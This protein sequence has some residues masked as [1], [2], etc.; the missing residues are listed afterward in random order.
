MRVLFY[1]RILC[2]ELKSSS[3]LCASEK[4]SR[5]FF[6]LFLGMYFFAL[7]LLFRFQED[8]PLCYTHVMYVGVASVVLVINSSK[9]R[10]QLERLLRYV[11]SG[12]D[13]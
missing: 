8:I 9:C 10:R 13:G 12:I 1:V 11:P 5:I 4:F 6:V 3:H 7:L 2:A